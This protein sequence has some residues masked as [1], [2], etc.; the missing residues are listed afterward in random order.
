M[1]KD[2]GE[3]GSNDDWSTLQSSG[4]LLVG[5]SRRMG[6]FPNLDPGSHG[7]RNLD[8]NA[9]ERQHLHL[10]FVKACCLIS[11][12]PWSY[13]MNELSDWRL[14]RSQNSKVGQSRLL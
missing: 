13:G 8:R 6:K 3:K 11:S 1:G 4:R 2:L 10:S 5:C 12:K 7:G 9:R 14:S